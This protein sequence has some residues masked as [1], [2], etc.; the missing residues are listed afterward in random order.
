MAKLTQ[1]KIV[2]T[3]S[4]LIQQTGRTDISLSVIAE[5][6]GITHGALYKH[7]SSKQ[8]LW[9]AVAADWFQTHI[10]QQISVKMNANDPKPVTKLHDWLWALVNA[11]KSAYEADPEMFALNTRYVDSNPIVLRRVLLPAY[12]QVD[13]LMQYHDANYQ[14]AETILAAFS[15]FMLPNFK[16]T[17]QQ[18]DYQ[19][20]FEA[21]WQLIRLG[22]S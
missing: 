10:L 8:A 7:F 22:V 4:A 12:Q 16:E 1:A 17:W 13:E 19:D 2:E 3:A 11:K 5:T 18:D 14:R 20:R 15:I 9:E 6:L 21:M